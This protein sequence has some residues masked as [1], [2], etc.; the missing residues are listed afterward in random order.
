MKQPPHRFCDLVMGWCLNRL[1]YAKPEEREQWMMA[2]FAPLPWEVARTP[3]PEDVAADSESF[4]N[5]AAQ[6]KG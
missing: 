6:L 4:M 3:R 1:Q 2:L 5:F